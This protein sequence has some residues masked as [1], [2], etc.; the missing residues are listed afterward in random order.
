MNYAHED[1]PGA[2]LTATYQ[3]PAPAH[4][5]TSLDDHCPST[6]TGTV[7]KDHIRI[8]K[9]CFGNL[10][11]PPGRR[12]VGVAIP[13]TPGDRCVCTCELFEDFR[14]RHRREVEAAVGA[15]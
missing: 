5:V 1:E 12:P 2:K 11:R 15:G 13:H 3:R 6:R 10:L 7:R 8:G 9:D 14:R 4:S